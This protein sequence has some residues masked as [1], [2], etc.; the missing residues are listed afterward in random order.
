MFWL[1]SL[2]ITCKLILRL[3]FLSK[4]IYEG[5][6]GWWSGYLLTPTPKA[7]PSY[8]GKEARTPQF[9]QSS[10]LH[11]AKFVFLILGQNQNKHV[12]LLCFFLTRLWGRQHCQKLTIKQSRATSATASNYPKLARLD[13]EDIYRRNREARKN[14]GFLSDQKFWRKKNVCVTKIYIFIAKSPPF[15]GVSFL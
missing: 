11:L 13:L 14:W 3:Y 7:S 2:V 1:F 5:A 8:S 10:T 15:P 12:K 9:W 4:W 6:L